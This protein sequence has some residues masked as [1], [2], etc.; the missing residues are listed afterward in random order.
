MIRLMQPSDL[1][2]VVNLLEWMDSAPEREVFAP[3]A[4]ELEGLRWE[5]ENKQSW[6]WQDDLGTVRA[7]TGLSPYKEGY[8]LEGPLSS[9]APHELLLKTTLEHTENYPVYAFAAKHNRAVRDCLES[10][11]FGAMH[12]TDFYTLPRKNA[13]VSFFIPEG[14]TLQP[15]FGIDYRQY[16]ELYRVSEDVWSER[17]SWTDEDY[18][19]HFATQEIQL[20]VLC[21]ADSSAT[22]ALGFA[23]LEIWGDV[24]KLSYLA[25]HPAYRGHGYG[26]VLLNHA[27][28]EAFNHPEVMTL[29]ARAHDHEGS[30]KHLYLKMGFA[31]ER[32]VITYLL[33]E[34]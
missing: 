28:R 13:K 18:R 16:L 21:R 33:E 7:Y 15:A 26:K 29:Q 8:V 12:G 22:Q 19:K 5:C 30:A 24:A 11:G 6:V 32:T 31:L 27:V 9:F 4:R 17:L 25:V 3:E 34:D 10:N 20:L 2:D 1:H 14:Y 23:E